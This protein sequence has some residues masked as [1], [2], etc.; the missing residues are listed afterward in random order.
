MLN[1]SDLDANKPNLDD[2]HRAFNVVFVDETGYINLCAE[3]NIGTFQRVSDLL[4][5]E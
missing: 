2:F 5:F 3:M 1:K 4:L